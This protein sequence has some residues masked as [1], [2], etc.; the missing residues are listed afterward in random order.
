MKDLIL[1][2]FTTTNDVT[3]DSKHICTCFKCGFH[4]NTKDPVPC[5]HRDSNSHINACKDCSNSF[6]LFSDLLQHHKAIDEAL[7]ENNVYSRNNILQ[8]DMLA[9]KVQIE[10][11]LRNF[12]HYR[13]HLAQ[14]K[15]EAKW[16]EE[17][18]ENLGEDECVVVFDFKMKILAS[19]Y[20]EK[21]KDWFSKR[22]FSC[23]GVMIVFG[24]KKNDSTEDNSENDVLYHMFF[25][26]DTTQDAIYVN[27]VKE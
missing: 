16:D 11:Q 25:S 6:Q 5:N 22:G 3:D 15:D 21:Q 12:L 13:S 24:H 8:D 23:L 26:D 4:D 1:I 27:T 18:C 14:A 7:E 2:L 17:F 20:R 9:W 19:Y 10:D